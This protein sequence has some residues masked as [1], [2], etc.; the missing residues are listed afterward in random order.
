[1]ASIGLRSLKS[2]GKLKHAHTRD[3][4]HKVPVEVA[5]DFAFAVMKCA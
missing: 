4:D 1:M 3:I 5:L 2:S